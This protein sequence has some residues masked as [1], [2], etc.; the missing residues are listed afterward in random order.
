MLKEK[1]LVSTAVKKNLKNLKANAWKLK[2]KL[3]HSECIIFNRYWV[4]TQIM[5]F[6]HPET[7][8]AS[9]FVPRASFC[10]RLCFNC[11]GNKNN[12]EYHMQRHTGE[13]WPF[14]SFLCPVLKSPI[15]PSG[16][17]ES[18]AGPLFQGHGHRVSSFFC[19]L[20]LN[21]QIRTGIVCFIISPHS[22]SLS[23]T[24]N[25]QL[26]YPHVSLAPVLSSSSPSLSRFVSSIQHC[27]S[28]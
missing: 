12:T 1:E 5:F 10:H 19:A 4:F 11:Y 25:F 27:M 28:L 23:S 2:S 8:L 14:L 16:L 15:Y 18:R 21:G 17:A 24:K 20:A 9:C 7:V 26:V 22:M 3:G 13:T 6:E